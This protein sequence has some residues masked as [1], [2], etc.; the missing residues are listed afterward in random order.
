M[1]G[2]N[3]KPKRHLAGEIQ[4]MNS[5]VKQQKDECPRDECEPENGSRERSS[6][7]N[8]KSMFE[9]KGHSKCHG[10]GNDLD[11]QVWDQK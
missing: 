3:H 5:S 9:A 4:M 1:Q 2:G 7:R 6:G 10:P 8:S 11:V